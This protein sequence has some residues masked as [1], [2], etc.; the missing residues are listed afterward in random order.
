MTMCLDLPDDWVGV[1]VE[2]LDTEDAEEDADPWRDRAEEMGA[3]RRAEGDE[4]KGECDGTDEEPA[5]GLGLA[6]HGWGRRV[7]GF[8]FSPGGDVSAVWYDKLLEERLSGKRWMEPIHEAGGWRDGMA[9]F[10]VE[11]RFRRAALRDLMAL[12]GCRE[13][14]DRDGGGGKADSRAGERWFDDPWLALDHLDD[15]WAYFSGL[16]PEVDAA[17]DVT[18]R[19][20]MR[21]VLPDERD[22]NRRRWATDPVWHIVQRAGFSHDAQTPLARVRATRHDLSQVD[23]ELY[24]LLKLRAALRGEFLEETATLSLELRDFARCM[25]EVDERKE[26]DFA[27]E[28]RE[29]A[30]MMGRPVPA[31]TAD[32]LAGIRTSLCDGDM[33]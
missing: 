27:D 8:S 10:R 11:A 31:R 13:G 30:R 4:D 24:G 5:D 15:L 22:S 7:S 6:V 28:V 19:G 23:A 18:W 29:K 1:P 2:L 26:R 17:P 14:V 33:A 9:L 3:A 12:G 32:L 20:W 25:E 21:L 16:P